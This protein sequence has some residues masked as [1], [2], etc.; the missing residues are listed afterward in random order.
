M[1]MSVYPIK[2]DKSC[3]LSNGLMKI[4]EFS[5]KEIIRFLKKDFKTVHNFAR[6]ND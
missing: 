5:V 4:T 6:H 3:S 2:I 1:N